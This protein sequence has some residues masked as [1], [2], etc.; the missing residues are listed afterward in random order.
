MQLYECNNSSRAVVNTGKFHSLQ[1][2][3]VSC[4]PAA[5]NKR[6]SMVNFQH[7]EGGAKDTPEFMGF[8]IGVGAH[9]GSDDSLH[10]LKSGCF[11]VPAAEGLVRGM[12]GHSE[13]AWGRARHRVA[14][15]PARALS[16]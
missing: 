7:S 10:P 14:M 8:L 3:P 11:P 4:C 15:V 13:G 16:F 5:T 9:R 6:V 12:N 1:R 2:S